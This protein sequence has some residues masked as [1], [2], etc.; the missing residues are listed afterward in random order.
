M[1]K[2]NKFDCKNYGCTDFHVLN[3]QTTSLEILSSL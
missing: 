3:Y 2:K 1:I